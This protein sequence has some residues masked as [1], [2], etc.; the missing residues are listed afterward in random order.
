MKLGLRYTYHGGVVH[1]GYV[2]VRLYVAKK[3]FPYKSQY[4]Y[5]IHL[6]K[7]NYVVS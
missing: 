6:F 5:F 7:K 1:L 2:K 3:I 4:T